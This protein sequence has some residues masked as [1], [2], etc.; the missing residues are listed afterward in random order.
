MRGQVP[1]KQLAVLPKRN[2]GWRVDHRT[3]CLPSHSEPASLPRSLRGQAL[4]CNKWH[5]VVRQHPLVSVSRSHDPPH[6]WVQPHVIL[7]VESRPVGYCMRH[8]PRGRA[9]LVGRPA[10]GN[11]R[12]RCSRN[13]CDNR[14]LSNLFLRD[15]RDDDGVL[16]EIPA[17]WSGPTP[18]RVR[19][20]LG[21]KSRKTGSAPKTTRKHQ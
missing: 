20:R 16:A 10:N 21:S 18:S 6:V 17:A 2:L 3:L 1:D 15:L 19:A 5:R 7:C 14:I 13:I 11:T 9:D 4:R 8:C 12:L